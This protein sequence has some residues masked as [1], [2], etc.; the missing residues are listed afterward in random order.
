[1][2]NGQYEAFPVIYPG[3]VKLVGPMSFKDISEHGNKG[4]EGGNGPITRWPQWESFTA[5]ENRFGESEQF[6]GS[7]KLLEASAGALDG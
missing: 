1:V 2:I 6:G 4:T 7:S 3:P 5:E